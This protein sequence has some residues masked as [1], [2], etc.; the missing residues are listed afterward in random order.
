MLAAVCLQEVMG[1]QWQ[2]FLLQDKEEKP[3]AVLLPSSAREGV[4]SP[5]TEVWLAVAFGAFSVVSSL[6]AAGIPLFQW[7]TNPFYTPVSQQVGRMAATLSPWQPPYHHGSHPITRLSGLGLCIPVLA[8][9]HQVPAT[10]CT[11]VGCAFSAPH[12]YI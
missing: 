6:Q 12:Q 9:R 4:L 7:L 2:I 8:L 5:V 1:D 10:L 3:T 11:Y